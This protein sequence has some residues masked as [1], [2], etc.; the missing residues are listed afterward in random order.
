MG[1]IAFNTGDEQSRLFGALLRERI[2]ATMKTAAL[3]KTAF[4]TGG[5]T[6][7]SYVRAEP[8]ICTHNARRSTLS[9][10]G[11]VGEGGDR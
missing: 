9:K 6:L 8:L 7:I 5:Q 1:V 2:S 3:R 11:E 4:K 10:G